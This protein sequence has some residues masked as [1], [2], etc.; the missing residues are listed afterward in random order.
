MVAGHVVVK[1]LPEVLDSIVLRTV[2]REEVL[3]E[4]I[5]ER[6]EGD[7][8]PLTGVDDEVVEDEVDALGP[9][10]N[11]PQLTEELDKEITVLLL[12]RN[13]DDLT[14]LG[15]ERP[16]DVPLLVDSRRQDRLLGTAQHPIPA[17]LRVEVDVG[18]VHVEGFFPT[19]QILQ[20]TVD[21]PQL[22]SFRGFRDWALHDGPRAAPSGI[23]GNQHP[24]NG[25]RADLNTCLLFEDQAEEFLGPGR[26]QV[27]VVLRGLAEELR[28]GLEEIHVDL[29]AA[30]FLS[31]VLQAFLTS[32]KE[33]IDNANGSGRRAANNFCDGGAAETLI[34]EED[35]PTPVTEICVPGL[36][37][38]SLKPPLHVA[39]QTKYDSPHFEP[40]A[41]I[42]L[43]LTVAGGF[44]L[45]EG[46]LSRGP[47]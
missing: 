15:V 41:T 37:H 19:A 29:G 17:D 2:R 26:P 38:G 10:I 24:S 13:P 18:L 21:S 1:L 35:D 46:R 43:E 42:H 31:A 20:H 25:R 34:V 28:Q 32:A 7:Q 4:N 16:S 23:E 39:G 5:A 33:S 6:L 9:R 12:R 8:G 45:N 3:F 11:L 30:V 44:F 14:G 22:A 47:S 36:L 27:T 40:P